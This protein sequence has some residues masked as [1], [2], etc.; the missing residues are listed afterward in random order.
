MRPFLFSSFNYRDTQAVFLISA[1]IFPILLDV[2]CK[3]ALINSHVSTNTIQGLDLFRL[4]ARLV[5]IGL[6]FTYLIRHPKVRSQM[7]SSGVMAFYVY[8]FVFNIGGFVLGFIANAIAGFIS[9]PFVSLIFTLLID[10]VALV[11][12]WMAFPVFRIRLQATWKHNKYRFLLFIPLFI[13]VAVGLN[14]GAG[15]LQNLVSSSQS[16]NQ[17]GLNASRTWYFLLV[18]GLLTILVAP[19]IEELATRHSIFLLAGNPWIGFFASICFFAE[20]HVSAANDLQ[21]I[22]AYF[23]GAIAL[24]TT[25]VIFQYNVYASILVHAGMNTVAFILFVAS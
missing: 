22:I 19:C 16:A 15:A 1:I 6:G 11:I 23:G 25:F 10:F 17:A 9:R 2:I 5:S 20:M 14:I 13:A 12:C 7:L 21:H 18:N 8:V 3:L 4:I 24:A